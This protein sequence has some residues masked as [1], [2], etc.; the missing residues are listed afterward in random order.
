MV[1]YEVTNH[2]EEARFLLENETANMSA[3][4]KC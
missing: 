2:T 1:N 3:A 4:E